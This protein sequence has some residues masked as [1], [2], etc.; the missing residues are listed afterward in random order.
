MFGLLF[1]LGLYALYLDDPDGFR[2]RYDDLLS[3]TGMADAP[4]LAAEFGSDLRTP[5]F[6]RGAFDTIR[7]DID[8]F[9]SLA[10]QSSA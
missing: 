4:T 10:A 8:Q 6:W 5:A 1:G 9:V 2:A 3:R 7:R